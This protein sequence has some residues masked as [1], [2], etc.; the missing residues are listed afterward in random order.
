MEFTRDVIELLIASEP[1]L[2][3]LSDHRFVQQADALRAN[4]YE[5]MN[6]RLFVFLDE[7][8]ASYIPTN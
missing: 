1:D 3:E 6:Q 2:A 4:D 8:V 5:D 7:L